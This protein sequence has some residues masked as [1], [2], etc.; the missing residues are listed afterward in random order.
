MECKAVEK[1]ER[2][3]EERNLMEVVISKKKKVVS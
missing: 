2:R 1:M 3:M